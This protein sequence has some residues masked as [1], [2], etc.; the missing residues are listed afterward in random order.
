[1]NTVIKISLP[2]LLVIFV[3][4]NRTNV[5]IVENTEVTSEVS[6]HEI[7]LSQEM[8][9][10]AKMFMQGDNLV[11]YQCE[12]D[13]LFSIFSDPLSGHYTNIGIK[14]RGPNEF[15]HIDVRSIVGTNE[16]FVCMDVGGL[17]KEVVIDGDKINVLSSSKI[18]TR[19]HPQNGIFVE[20][21]YLSMNL[22]NEEAEFILYKYTDNEPEY[23]CAYPEWGDYNGEMKAFTYIK[24]TLK[25]PAENKVAS[26]YANFRKIRI[27]DIN[28]GNTIDVDV[29]VPNTFRR[30]K[31]GD[32]E[33]HIAY[34]SYPCIYNDNIYALCFN[35]S[36]NED[37]LPEIHVFD[38]EG[39]LRKRILLDKYINVFVIDTA[40]D[41]L[42]GMNT[43][44]ANTL[45]YHYFKN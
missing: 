1:M 5:R 42:Y 2:F 4:C 37:I 40:N 38:W 12:G 45:Y 20:N 34:G 9:M 3:C 32:T 19:K 6:L 13:T 10:P 31:P 33:N 11:V 23:L 21:G 15:I 27:L 17:K 16:G 7:E 29:R 25:H 28:E 43:N 18:N 14:G 24:H 39:N 36:F 22:A 8:L 44:Q 30:Y 35:G 26:L 41:L